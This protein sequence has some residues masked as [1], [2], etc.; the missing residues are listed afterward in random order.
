[1]AFVNRFIILFLVLL[2]C[3]IRPLAAD[4][5]VIKLA[6]EADLQNG[7][8]IYE[9]CASCHL[10]EGWG[11]N[12]G[13]YPQIAGQHQNVLIQQLLDIRSGRR[14]NPTMYPFVQE[15]TIGGYQSLADV[16]VYISTLPMHPQHQKGPWSKGSKQFKQG[17]KLFEQHC[18]NCHG[19]DAGG[20]NETLTP[21][22]YGQHYPYISR[23]I[24]QIKNGIRNVNP[25]MQSIVNPLSENQLLLITNYVSYL[26]VPDGEL[27]PSLDWRNTDFY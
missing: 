22:L 25:V 10:P 9:T 14:E 15:R 27:A 23:Q 7:K 4:P 1:M 19:R 2:G 21:K 5:V 6:F 3:F 20:D 24:I 18:A 11:N 26:P 13:T 16:V 12:D 17:K 8:R